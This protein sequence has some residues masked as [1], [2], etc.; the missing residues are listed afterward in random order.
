MNNKY[1]IKRK[2]GISVLIPSQNEEKTIDLCI[3][4]FI[5]FA[6]EM[7]IVD[8][9]STDNTINII[10]EK[11]NKFPDKIKFFNKPD[12]QH[13]SDNRQVALEHSCYEWIMRCDSD[14]V[15][16]T[17]GEYNIMNFKK[18]LLKLK[19]GLRPE[20]ILVPQYNLVKD[21]WHTGIG[22]KNIAY[23]PKTPPVLRFYRYIPFFKFKRLGRWEGVRFQ[24]KFKKI[25]WKKPLWM[26]CNFK[27]DMNFFLRSERT[28]WREKGDF[29]KFPTL[30]SYI[31]CIIK[32]K[33]DTN[34]MD[35]AAKKYM[36][37]VIL[38]KLGKYDEKKFA[39]YPKLIREKMKNGF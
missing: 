18:Y 39:P 24:N 31:K 15:A 6:D 33:Y 19:R 14:F 34:S 22:F 1:L 5:E 26:H 4:S 38:P 21:Y 37:S 16:Y 10:K 28:N 32:D 7:I 23:S 27:T 17:D 25:I 36:D 2:K 12:I 9:G 30:E 29:N 35:I 20:G 11:K 8:N 3:E 13:L